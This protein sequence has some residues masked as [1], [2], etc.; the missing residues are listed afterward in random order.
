MIENSGWRAFDL[1]RL[2]YAV[3]GGI[4]LLIILVFAVLAWNQAEQVVQPAVERQLNERS[5]SVV[6]VLESYVEGA[7]VDIELL[8]VSPAVRNVAARENERARAFGSAALDSLA[9]QRRGGPPGYVAVNPEIDEYFRT[10][11]E[12]SLFDELFVTDRQGFVVASGGQD[13]G[14]VQSDNAWW[15]EAYA[16]R[17]IFTRTVDPSSGTI[18]LASALPIENPTGDVVGVLRAVVDL[19]RLRPVL[20]ELARGWGYVQVIDERGFVIIDQHEEHLLTPHPEPG[21]LVS[22][23]LLQSVAPDGQRI[24]GMARPALEGWT[25]AYWVPAAEAFDLLTAARRAVAWG[26]LLVLGTAILGILIA[27]AWVSREIGEPVKMVAGAADRVGSG[28]LRARVTTV[29]KGEIAKLCVAVQQMID[30]LNELV[31]SLREAGFYT[32]SRSQ[33]IAGAVEQL[34]AGTEE[35]TVTLSRLTGEAARYSETIQEVNSRMDS[36]G[37]GARDLA[38]G[39]KMATERSR[40]LRD[41]AEANRQRLSG[42]RAEVNQMAERSDLATSQLLEFMDASRQFSEFVDLIQGFARRTNLLALNAAIEAA[43][44]GGEARG[45]GVL[46]DE[47]RKLSNQAGEAADRAQDTTDAILG[48]LES[49]RQAVGETRE[50]THAIGSVVESVDESFQAINQAMSEAESWAE[51]VAQVS[52]EVDRSVRSTGDRLRDVVSGFTDFA[53]AMEELAAGMEEQNASTEEIAAAVM[54]LNNAARE[55]ASM[56]EV[57]TVEDDSGIDVETGRQAKKPAKTEIVRAA[58]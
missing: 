19:G 41:M 20:A 57:F 34:S 40:Q 15:R 6:S 54:A 11:V 17:Q 42:G 32:Q 24:V 10:V 13:V 16:G 58:L 38:K 55:L 39:A 26:T 29:G 52:A 44:A 56:A 23:R 21:A 45:F 18:A 25:V 3:V 36:L 37:A 1:R 7:M 51:R 50:A 31:G 48:Q 35:M 53:A 12:R 30:R 46:A 33:E 49:A 8:A 14:P 27:G 5:S 43:R 22:G 28:D 9:A 47:I 4:L 2:L